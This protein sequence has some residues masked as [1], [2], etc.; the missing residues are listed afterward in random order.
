VEQFRRNWS[1]GK[2]QLDWK[3]ADTAQLRGLTMELSRGGPQ[4]RR[5]LED[6]VRSSLQFWG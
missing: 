2:F 1:G 3:L 5:R 4:D 6:I